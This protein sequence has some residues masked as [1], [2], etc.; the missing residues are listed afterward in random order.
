MTSGDHAG[1]LEDR[2]TVPLGEGLVGRAGQFGRTLA[3]SSAGSLATEYTADT[4]VAVIA[5]P[6]IV[7]AR[8]VGVLELTSKNPVAIDASK[9]DVVH[10][11]TGQAAS[12]VEAA[13]FHERADELSHTDVLTR[14]PNRRR[15]EVDLDAEVA[16]STRYNR[17]VA[18]IMLDVDHFKSVNDL[19][20]H[21]AGDEVLSEFQSAFKASLRETDTAYRYGG[22]EFCVILRETDG[23]AAAVVAERLRAVIAQRF[24]GVGGSPMVTA[25]LGIASIPADAIDATSLV[26][27]ADKAMYQ[28]KALG[29]NCVMRA[30]AGPTVMNG[31]EV[32]VRSRH[33]AITT[34]SRPVAPSASSGDKPVLTVSD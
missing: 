29:R 20:G 32:R 17:P 19:H 7:G 30:V 6:M 12:A 8:I 33:R 27:A 25:S 11:L 15:L 10:S 24:A 14:L 1:P 5:L 31:A 23:D 18:F 22:E 28:A 3:T 26:A 34:P 16:R 2:E 4:P 21:Q 13:R 9:L